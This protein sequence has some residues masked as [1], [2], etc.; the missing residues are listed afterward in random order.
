MPTTAAPATSDTVRP[1]TRERGITGLFSP[2]F[3]RHLARITRS[4]YETITRLSRRRQRLWQIYPRRTGALRV[5]TA[6]R[7]HALIVR[8]IPMI[9]PNSRS[10]NS[11]AA[12]A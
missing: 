6:M 11:A 8:I 5:V 3:A 10:V 9:C 7:F 12:R 2:S 1:A 4:D